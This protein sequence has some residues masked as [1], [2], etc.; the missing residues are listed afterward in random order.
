[1]GD[2]TFWVTRDWSRRD[3]FRR[4]KKNIGLKVVQIGMTAAKF[5]TVSEKP[6]KASI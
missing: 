2:E 1:M 3:I 6:E 5:C 4:R